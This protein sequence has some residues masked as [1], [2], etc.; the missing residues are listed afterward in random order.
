MISIFAIP[1]AFSR[2][3]KRIQL[4]A[5]KSWLNLKNQKRIEIIL[6][7]DEE[8]I[9]RICQKYSLVHIPNILKNV[10]ETPLLDDCFKKAIEKAK[11]DLV[12]YI[13][14]DIVLLSDF[15]STINKIRFP[16]FLLTGRRYNLTINNELKFEKNWEEKLK[17]RV[18]KETKLYKFGAL[19]YFV[20]PKKINFNLPAFAVGRTAW[21]NWLVYRARVMR[22]PVIDA[23]YSITA[24]HQE[25]DYSHAKGLRNVWFGK[26]REYNWR[27]VGDRRKFFNI[28]DANWIVTKDGIKKASLNLI[29]SIEKFPTL[30]LRWGFIFEPMILLIKLFK[31]FS[32]KTH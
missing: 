12:C 18:K 24:I 20:F 30:H 19:D 7:G 11:F 21:D 3:F 23:S 5:I 29:R 15:L 10:Y 9:D 32:R 4:N 26:E 17:R 31:F 16:E 13:N 25:H 8:G 14:S 6:L 2:Q 27:L 22:V 1:K 28:K